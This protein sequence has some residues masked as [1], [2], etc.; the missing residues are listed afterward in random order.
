MLLRSPTSAPSPYHSSFSSIHRD[1]LPSAGSAK[2]PQLAGTVRPRPPCNTHNVPAEACFSGHPDAFVDTFVCGI[3]RSMPAHTT[4][5]HGRHYIALSFYSPWVLLH[6]VAVSPGNHNHLRLT[7]HP[8]DLLGHPEVFL[9][10]PGSQSF[11]VPYARSSLVSSFFLPTAPLR[12]Y[13]VQ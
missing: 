4:K 12:S 13:R 1:V 2:G 5:F 7:Y 11:Y 10:H 6:W 9:K 3:H 8:F